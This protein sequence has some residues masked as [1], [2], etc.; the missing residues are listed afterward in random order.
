M[1][2]SPPTPAAHAAPAQPAAAKRVAGTGP[3]SQAIMR[4]ADVRLDRLT[5]ESATQLCQTS[6]AIAAQT[7]MALLSQNTMA[8][9]NTAFVRREDAV[10]KRVKVAVR[11]AESE[12][13]LI[14]IK[15]KI[16]DPNNPNKKTD[17]VAFEPTLNGLRKLNEVPALQIIRPERVFVDGKEQGNPFIQVHPDKRLPE[18][19]YARA[20]CV[21]YSP[22]GQFVASDVMI[23][24]DVNVYLIENIQAKMKWMDNSDK[25]AIYGTSTQKP[26]DANDKPIAG[27][28]RPLPVHAAGD[29]CLWVNLAAPEVHEI[30]RDHTTR[31]KFLE[32]LAQSFAERNALKAHPAIPKSGSGQNGVMAFPM[33]SWISDFDRRDLEKLRALV[34]EDRL[35]EFEDRSGNKVSVTQVTVDVD[36]DTRAA[37]EEGELSEGRG[38]ERSEGGADH[39]EESGDDQP[40]DDAGIDQTADQKDAGLAGA[41][42]LFAD[43]CSLKGMAAAKKVMSECGLKQ[44]EEATN[45][46]LQAFILA[47][48]AKMAEAKKPSEKKPDEKKPA[49]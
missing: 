42:Q 29:L 27:N 9:P 15:R 47:A 4:P 18:V 20:I 46:E 32:R 48:R 33:T 17:V 36:E 31:L 35:E 12:G 14:K 45:E 41:T 49:D 34:E 2:D 38:F 11:L 10:L 3:E 19:V 24:L 13:H 43:L 40:G 28:W 6:P 22:T 26:K 1:A 7:L 25:L 5:E 37:V 39:D 44:L 16:T 21:G 8:L 30:L 23:R